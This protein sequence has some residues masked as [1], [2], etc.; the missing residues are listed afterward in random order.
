MPAVLSEVNP[1][2]DDGCEQ[3]QTEEEYRADAD[4]QRFLRNRLPGAGAVLFSRS[5]DPQPSSNQ[6]GRQPP[7]P[8]LQDMFWT[9]GH[10]QLEIFDEPGG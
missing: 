5:N 2:L 8:G 9:L 4:V 1:Q 3:R 10:H 6:S 7:R